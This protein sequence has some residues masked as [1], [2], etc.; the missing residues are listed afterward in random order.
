MAHFWVDTKETT[1]ITT[2][3]PFPIINNDNVEKDFF[4]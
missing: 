2:E 3:K 4:F 1:L